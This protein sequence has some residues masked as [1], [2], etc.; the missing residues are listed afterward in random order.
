M[1]L[2]VEKSG[3]NGEGIGYYKQ[4]PIFI[5]GALPSEEVEVE[6]T[7]DKARYGVAE[8]KKILSASKHRIN[9]KCKV[10]YQ[11]GGCPLMVA[12]YN[13]QLQLKRENLIQTL[14][15]YTGTFDFGLLRAI[16]SNPS[17]FGYRNAIKMPFH[18]G[19]RLENGLY[20]SGTNHIVSVEQ[21]IIHDPT[22]E[23]QRQEILRILNKHHLNDFNP[24]KSSGLRTLVMRHFE[25]YTQV[26]LVS[27]T[28]TIPD[29]VFK[30]ISEVEGVSSV[31]HSLHTSKNSVETFGKT[32]EHK[33][34]F[35]TLRFDYANL[36]L[37]LLPTAFF[38]LNPKQAQKLFE[39]VVDQVKQEDDVV[40][41][42][43]GVG[44][45]SLMIAK[46]AKSV[47]GI[48]LNKEAIFAANR[49]TKLNEIKNAK[50]V[51]ND[52][53]I[54]L[55]KIKLRDKVVV[56]D[57]PRSGLDESMIQVL[58][59]NPAK[60]VVYVSCNPSTLAK[61]IKDLKKLYKIDSIQPFDFFSQ[62][63]L[64]ETVVVLTRL[65]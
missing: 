51:D 7:E 32:V 34:G 17:P 38:Q 28:D 45:L 5:S 24:P 23:K 61:N 40:D 54:E 26:T 46:K 11:C 15:K 31:Y 55:K 56:V 3:I 25:A 13:H 27:G 16:I 36:V 44:T 21:C 49:N 1:K 62:T 37:E 4:K 59:K 6:I 9:P 41:V 10:Q 29:I 64:L 14:L 43:C 42:Y 30:E 35:K 50:F 39:Y 65:K 20:K 8:L 19:K 63:P 47:F 48:E 52:A 18:K 60:K 33:A 22:L 12:D 58:L 53:A 2:K 57:P